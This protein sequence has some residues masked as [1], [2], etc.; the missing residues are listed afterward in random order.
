MHTKE[1]YLPRL[2][3]DGMVLQCDRETHIWGRS[4][5][6]KEI[7]IY[8]TDGNEVEISEKLICF[9]GEDGRWDCTLPSMPA[10]AKVSMKITDGITEREVKDILFG[11]VWFCSG[12]SN[13]DLMMDRVKDRYPGEITE[14]ENDEIRT[15][16]IEPNPVYE[17]PL[18]ELKSGQ[19][20]H[21]FFFGY[22]LF[23][24]EIYV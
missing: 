19:G 10:C 20:Y 6:K 1:L 3:S 8:L 9:A 13:M 5:P 7:V 14:C 18:E 17:G 4:A 23:F 16:V 21:I 11:N 15:F 12:Q 22:R 2:I 24:R